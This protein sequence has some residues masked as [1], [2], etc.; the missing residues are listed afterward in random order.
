MATLNTVMDGSTGKQL[1]DTF[2]ANDEALNTDITNLDARVSTNETDIETL[3]TNSL[4]QRYNAY[5]RVKN[6]SAN[7]IGVGEVCYVIGTDTTTSTNK[8]EVAKASDDTIT[9]L[10]VTSESI[11]VGS[12]GDI[13]T[14]GEIT[15]ANTSALTAGAKVYLDDSGNLSSTA[16]ANSVEIGYCIISDASVGIIQ[17]KV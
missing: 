15:G 6:G 1:V 5:I 7:A 4:D 3:Q 16:G 12:L 13:V 2:Y 8:L 11:A 10:G 9:V 17:I 14:V